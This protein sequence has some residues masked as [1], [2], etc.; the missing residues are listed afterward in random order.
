MAPLEGLRIVVAGATSLLGKELVEA[1]GAGRFAS[2]ELQLLDEEIVAGTL[3][4]AAGEAFVV[5]PVDA[6]SF[7]RAQLTFFA[8]HP[9]FARANVE[10]ALRAG[11]RVID[12]SGGLLG[13]ES[14]AVSIP[15]LEDALPSGSDAEATKQERSA[16]REWISPSAA[17][18]VACG[19]SAAL[20][21]W[22]ECALS[23]LFLRPVSERGIEGIEELETQ[24]VK[25][26]SFQPIAQTV[27]DAQVAFNILGRFGAGSSETLSDARRVI[28]RSVLEYLRARSPVPATQLIQVPSFY[29]YTF[30]AFAEFKDAPELSAIEIELEAAGFRF[31]DDDEPSPSNISA[32]GETRA[33]L[34]RLEFDPNRPNALWLWGAVDNVKLAAANAVAI[35]DEVIE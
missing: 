30:S 32:A 8:G 23:V 6:D 34:S 33:I 17:A 10:A 14:A 24:T 9:A 4:A 5:R 21:Q 27:F 20:K 16:T 1:L 13:R 28:A 31:A 2:A 19:I 11:S 25:L 26:L 3:A 7:E 22:P 35:A 29:S 15:S 18:I 12:L